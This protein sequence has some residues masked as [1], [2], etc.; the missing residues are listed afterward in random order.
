M[1]FRQPGW[2]SEWPVTLADFTAYQGEIERLFGLPEVPTTARRS[3]P[4]RN[5]TAAAL[6]PRL[7]KWPPFK[8]RNVATLLDA[9]IKA[10]NG[11]YVWLNATATQFAS[12]PR[13]NPPASVEARSPDGGRLLIRPEETVIAAGAIESTRLLLLID[14]QNDNRLFAPDGVLGRY[15]HDHVSTETA[16]VAV[17]DRTALNRVIGFRF[18]G[19]GMRNLRFEPSAALRAAHQLPAGFLHIAFST[20]A[21]TGFDVL[22]SV[23]RKIQ[24]RDRFSIGDVAELTSALPWLSAPRGGASAKSGCSFPTMRFSASTPSSSRSRSPAIASA[25]RRSG[26][27]PSA[28]RWRRSTGA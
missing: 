18:E 16:R 24:R 13:R 4:G 6:I 21:P 19:G 5:G 9:Q 7:A 20:E 22:R 11:P 17:S 23:F 3:C 28:V 12:I 27:T 25:C 15:F 1:T 10:E 26:S 8:L 14:H 2:D